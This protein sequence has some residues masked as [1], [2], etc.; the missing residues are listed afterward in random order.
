MNGD[1]MQKEVVNV[2]LAVANAVTAIRAGKLEEPDAKLKTPR[3]K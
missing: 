3:A 2:A 1:D